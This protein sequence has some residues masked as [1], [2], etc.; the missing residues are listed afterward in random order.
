MAP[1]P[2][3]MGNSTQLRRLGGIVVRV[4]DEHTILFKPVLFD[5]TSGQT[6]VIKTQDSSAFRQGQ[7]A[8]LSCIPQGQF[9][10]EAKSGSVGTMEG[11]M[12]VECPTHE[13]YRHD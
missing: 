5:D 2:F 6:I 7:W 11:H 13:Q 8:D 10:Y 12:I 1:M 9:R 4:L 3:T